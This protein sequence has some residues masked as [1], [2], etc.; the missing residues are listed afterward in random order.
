MRRLT[1]RILLLAGVIAPGASVVRAQ[2]LEVPMQVGPSQST[3]LG[4]VPA[5]VEHSPP[6]RLL[7]EKKPDL[8]QELLQMEQSRR[9]QTEQFKQSLLAEHLKKE[10]LQSKS[11]QSEEVEVTSISENS[12]QQDSEVVVEDH[13]EVQSESGSQIQAQTDSGL[14]AQQSEE[15]EVVFISENRDQQDSEVLVEEYQEVQSESGPQIQGQADS[16][17]MAQQSEEDQNVVNSDPDSQLS[18]DGSALIDQST[19]PDAIEL[20][21]SRPKADPSVLP[22]AATT[23]SEPLAPLASPPSLALP[24]KPSQVRIRELR[25]LTL[26]QVEELVELNNPSLKASASQVDQAKSQ[27]RTEISRWYPTVDLSANGLP[28]YFLQENYQYLGSPNPLYDPADPDGKEPE[29]IRQGTSSYAKRFSAT[30]TA[31]VQWKLIDPERVPR[32]SAARDAYEK[33]Q[34]AYLITLR[35]LRLNTAQQYFSLQNADEQVRIGQAAVRASQV[36]LQIAR[37]RLQAGVVNKLEVLEA[38]TQLARDQR[39]LTSALGSQ[40]SARRALASSLDLP[41]DITPTAA[42]PAQ[43]TGVWMPSLQESIVAAYTFREELD[44]FILDISISNS[45]ANTALAAIQ[46]IVSLVNRFSTNRSDG[47]SASTFEEVD[48]QEYRWAA[49]NAV[50]LNASW[51]IFDGGRARAQYRKY[52]QEAEENSFL[53]A[54]KRDEIRF[55]VEDSFYTLRSSAKNINTTSREVLSSRESLRLARLR[56]EAG[57]TTQREVID[58]QRDL[59]QAEVKY[60]EAITNYNINLAKL[61]RSTGLD[62]IQKCSAL[63]L[64]SERP[65]TEDDAVPIIPIPEKSACEAS[66]L[67]VGYIPS[68]V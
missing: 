55:Q 63:N 6:N 2:E 60:S 47:G 9:M 49:D 51:Q 59:T 25:P 10:S 22:P 46:P 54:G 36:S 40:S 7:L 62:Q 45:N 37:A 42:T 44:Q 23:I 24:D 34:D 15:V 31:T 39:T 13:Q 43:V 16:G 68:G 32:I 58:N 11:R 48:M 52:K 56:F 50:L 18:S 41:Q 17:V 27:L 21:G 64:P 28:E 12:D 30:F 66:T 29:T 65:S 14:M 26:E 19:L 20:K 1:A 35:E 67:P 4:S 33:A 5:K 38:E 3:I 53:F 8:R 61:R 57:V